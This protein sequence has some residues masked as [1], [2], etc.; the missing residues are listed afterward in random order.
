MYL[1]TVIDLNSRRVVG[2]AVADHMRTTL[3]TDALTMALKSREPKG[4][5]IFHSDRGTQYWSVPEK[6]EAMI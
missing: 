4:K 2:W 1:A 5:V 6:V 3:I